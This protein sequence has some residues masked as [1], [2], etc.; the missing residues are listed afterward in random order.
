VA[1]ISLLA[2]TFL[3]LLS[4]LGSLSARAALPDKDDGPSVFED[5][6][7]RLNPKRSELEEDRI[8]AAA[9]FAEGRLLFKRQDFA[10][11]LRRYQRALRSD[12]DSMVA[13]R[14]IVDLAFSLRRSGEGARYA[15]ILAE[16]VPSDPTLMRRLA[17][18]LTQQG[19]TER[20]A[21]LYK[22]SFELEK[23]KPV[24]ADGVLVRLEAGRLFLLNGDYDMASELFGLVAESLD[25]PDAYGLTEKLRKAI[26]DKEDKT[27]A[28]FGE[29]FRLAGRFDEAI[30][31]FKKSHEAKN[32]EALLELRLALVFAKK[33]DVDDAFAHLEKALATSVQT[34]SGQQYALLSELLKKKVKDE[35]EAKKQLV[36]RLAKL[37]AENSKDLVLGYYLADLYRESDQLDVAEPIY[38]KQLDEKPSLDGYSGLIDIYTRGKQ[39]DKLTKIL[40][41]TLIE[42]GTFQQLDKVLDKLVADEMLA[43]EYLDKVTKAG[44]ADAKS[45]GNGVALSAAIIAL[46]SDKV[47]LGT[48]L[49]ELALEAEKPDRE[50]TVTTWGL[51]L[52]M[53][54]KYEPAVKV[55]RRGLE[56][57]WLPKDNPD[58]HFYLAGALEMSGNTEDALKAA[59]AAAKLRPKETRYQSRVPWVIYHAKQYDEAE[60]QYLELLKKFDSDYRTS[61]VRET[62]REARFVLSNICVHQER[63][64]EAEEW[65]EQVLDEFPENIGAMNDLGYLWAD[66]GKN[67]Q[68]AL[69]MIQKAVEAEPENIAYLDSLGWILYRVGRYE[70]AVRE[71][72][73]AAAGDEPDA[74]I[75]DHLAD[76][77]LKAGNKAKA[78]ET[79]RRA[80][81][82]LDDGD[83]KKRTEIEQKLKKHT[84][85]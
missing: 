78:L 29:A 18:H 66:G 44:T 37:Y 40:G 49:F 39:V 2:L 68:R 45:L 3:V 51:E 12:P 30:A 61:G 8:R 71:L 58:F 64:A 26:L 55:F 32:D 21:A 16:K 53:E 42:A 31:M 82:R 38:R 33:D 5:R 19:E 85:E 69:G 34:N 10:G 75:L 80:I 73:K 46:K 60:K 23:D 59:K 28:M 52:F 77:Y 67:L 14:E 43:D 79:W 36:E 13:L 4:I 9:L 35:T 22:K 84:A 20:A 47:E 41:E 17:M 24:R 54:D 62:M 57:G 48:E 74:V 11:A 72:A 15:V 65:L 6:P 70:D 25:K 7:E 50:R 81:K 56:E 63:T 83:A 27:Y 76:A 1:R